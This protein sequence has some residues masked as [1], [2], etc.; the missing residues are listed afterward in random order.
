MGQLQTWA[1][2]MHDQKET[3]KDRLSHSIPTQTQTPVLVLALSL[4]CGSPTT[5]SCIAVQADVLSLMLIYTIFISG[6]GILLQEDNRQAVQ[7][8]TKRRTLARH[9]VLNRKTALERYRNT[10]QKDRGNG[11]FIYHTCDALFLSNEDARRGYQWPGY[12]R[13]M[14]AEEGL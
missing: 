8:Y 5:R 4:L 1:L 10:R 12:W 2:C 11:S 6:A 7:W 14:R 9:R 13:K 3:E